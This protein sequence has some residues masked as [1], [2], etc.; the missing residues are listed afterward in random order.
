MPKI[1]L[2]NMEYQL[3]INK[4][5]NRG[6]SLKFYY[7]N[8]IIANANYR[9]TNDFII[10]QIFQNKDKIIKKFLKLIEQ[11]NKLKFEYLLSD[12]KIWLFG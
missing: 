1:Y 12:Q 4:T 8:E 3:T 7:P 6:I 9:L 10:N 5:R 2:D 11:A